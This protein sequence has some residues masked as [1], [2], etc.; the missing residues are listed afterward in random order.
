[1]P[2]L[3]LQQSTNLL[4]TNGWMNLPD[5]QNVVTNAMTLDAVFYRLHKP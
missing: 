4:Q 1:M 2:G 5:G 3:F